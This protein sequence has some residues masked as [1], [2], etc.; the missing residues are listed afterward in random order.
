MGWG[1]YVIVVVVAL[2]LIGATVVLSLLAWQRQA[3]GIVHGLVAHGESVKASL[4]TTDILVSRLATG[5]VEDLLAFA[6]PAS[7]DRS[8]L[9]E[10]A[11]RMRL[12]G[13]ELADQR[14]PRRMW[15]LGDHL[16]AAASALAEECGRVG[17]APSAD[18]LDALLSLDLERVRGELSAVEREIGPVV[19]AYR[20]G[21]TDVYGGG[22]YI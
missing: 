11:S 14:L 6:E 10:V 21:D 22:L 17:E 15:A 1:A 2:V 19:A 3:R 5:S 9:A 8:V 12:V 7:E 16:S 20:L 18:V 13:L 4:K